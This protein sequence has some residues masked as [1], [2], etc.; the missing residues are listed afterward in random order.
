MQTTNCK[1]WVMLSW[2]FLRSAKIC[3]TT[4]N[5]T[6][7]GFGAAYLGFFFFNLVMDDAYTTFMFFIPFSIEDK[8]TFFDCPSSSCHILSACAPPT[9]TSSARHAKPSCS[10]T[11][12]LVSSGNSSPGHGPGFWRTGS[13]SGHKTSLRC[14][15]SG[16]WTNTNASAFQPTGV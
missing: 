9:S 10:C 15:C 5:F 13:P 12:T 4:L 11:H 3:D 8:I 7:D 16:S 14:S 6:R 2:L 1:G